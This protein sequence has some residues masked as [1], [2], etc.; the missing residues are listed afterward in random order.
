MLLLAA[1]LLLTLLDLRLK[2]VVV[3]IATQQAR[4]SATRSINTA[5]TSVMEDGGLTYNDIVRVNQDAAGG[6]SSLQANM[7]L[8]NALKLAATERIMEEAGKDENQRV[9]VPLGTLSGIQLA[10]GLGPDVTVRL[11]PS[12]YVQTRIYN[13]FTSAGINQTMHRIMLEA[14][15]QFLVVIP[16]G[17]LRAESTTEYCVAETVIVGQVPELYAGLGEGF[18]PTVAKIE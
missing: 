18:A 14:S 16:G 15:I 7:A 10:A 3:D 9:T 6:I 17:A 4:M 5:M 12:G 8:I 13:Q 11:L 1:A 2:R